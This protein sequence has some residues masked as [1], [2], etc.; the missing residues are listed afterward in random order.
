MKNYAVIAVMLIAAITVLPTMSSA[1]DVIY[2]VDVGTIVHDYNLEDNSRIIR[3]NTPERVIL[4]NPLVIMGSGVDL[5]EREGFN[6]YTRDNPFNEDTMISDTSRA[7]MGQNL[8]NFDLIVV[9]GPDHNQYTKEL[10]ERGIIT[11]RQTNEKMPGLV[12]EMGRSPSG[13]TILVVG[14]TASYPYHERDLPLNGI[15]P[16]KMAPAAA[17]VTGTIFGLIGILLAKLTGFFSTIWG[18]IIN[19][20]M[21]FLSTQAGEMASEKESEARKVKVE[22]KKKAI[23]LGIT[24]KEILIGLVCAGLFG[25]AYVIA[26][27]LA[28]LPGNIVIY[29]V[30][31]GLVTVLHDFGHRLVAW[32]Y[33]TDS[34]FRFWGLGTVIMLLTSWLFGTVFAQPGRFLLDKEKEHKPRDMALITLAGPIISLLLTIAFMPLILF[35]GVIGEIG[36]LGFSMNLVT[37]VYN[38]MPFSPMDGKTIWNWSKVFW[39]LLFIPVLLFFMVMTIFIL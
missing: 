3:V 12:I 37:V 38:L 29:L 6:I 5:F 34:E 1:Q 20:V 27:R 36:L 2:E 18:K 25:I 19:F 16:E 13:H 7:F 30:I 21:G 11:Y 14:D 24:L 26:D 33:K 35:G 22:G 15:I 28:L 39:A 32:K 17:V 8:D 10:I 9:G 23:F 4:T 31:A